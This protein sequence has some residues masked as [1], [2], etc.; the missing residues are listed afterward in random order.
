MPFRLV[1]IYCLSLRVNDNCGE[2]TFSAFA[3]K[4]QEFILWQGNEL[5]GLQDTGQCWQCHCWCSVCSKVCM[6]NTVFASRNAKSKF[7][8]PTRSTTLNL[9]GSFIQQWWRSSMK[10]LH[11]FI[12][13]WHTFLGGLWF[14]ST[15]WKGYSV[16]LRL[17]DMSKCSYE[18]PE[19]LGFR[20]NF[21]HIFR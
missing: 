2:C 18:H 17:R 7:L 14:C 5:S 21:G 13:K 20:K 1:W 3:D 12:K 15:L 10:S 19:V 4:V 9:L 6:E 16:S 11:V 8:S